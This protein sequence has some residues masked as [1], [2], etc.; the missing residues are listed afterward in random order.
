MQRGK[1]VYVASPYTSTDKVLQEIRYI[2]AA[3]GT[4]WLMNT[5]QDIS[6]YSPISHTHPIATYC[7]LP[8]HWEF[9]KQFDETVLSRCNEIWVLCLDGWQQSTGVTAELQIAVELGLPVK[10]V[11]PL[12]NGEYAV[13]HVFLG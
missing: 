3:V 12:G 5:Y 8:G 11:Q 4:G 9:W 6:F 10:Y 13:T 2:G 1:L 7:K